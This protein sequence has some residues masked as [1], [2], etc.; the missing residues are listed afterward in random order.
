MNKKIVACKIPSST[1]TNVNLIYV[2][3][4]KKNDGNTEDHKT[5]AKT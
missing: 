3:Q 4:N 2:Q 1:L 5:Q